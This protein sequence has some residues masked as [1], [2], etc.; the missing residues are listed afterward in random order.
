MVTQVKAS[1]CVIKT[2]RCDACDEVLVWDELA[3]QWEECAACSPDE[4][5]HKAVRAAP[6]KR[7]SYKDRCAFVDMLKDMYGLPS[8]EV[9]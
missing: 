8:V 4:A 6:L 3:P 1:G 9:M 5:C 7:W 2:R